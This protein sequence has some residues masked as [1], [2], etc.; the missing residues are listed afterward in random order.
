MYR[1]GCGTEMKMGFGNT[2]VQPAQ[3]VLGSCS[4]WRCLLDPCSMTDG[5]DG[6]Q[7]HYLVDVAPACGALAGRANKD[8]ACTPRAEAPV[9]TLQEHA[10]GWLLI[11]AADDAG[12]VIWICWGCGWG[13]Q[14]G[15]LLI[16]RTPATPG[17][18]AGPRHAIM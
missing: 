17:T 7:L 2:Y 4:S 6:F 18:G 3:E 15:S 16:L 11:G 5:G 9:T 12:V 10:A 8:E 1:I 14:R 13:W